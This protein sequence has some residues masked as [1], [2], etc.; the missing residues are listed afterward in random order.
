MV[1]AVRRFFSDPVRYDVTF[2]I[3]L[4]II[5]VTVDPVLFKSKTML[6]AW[7]VAA[8]LHMAIGGV[9]LLAVLRGLPLAASGVVAGI[10]LA[11]AIFAF[12]FS[13]AAIA[14]SAILFPAFVSAFGDCDG[15]LCDFAAVLAIPFI[16]AGLPALLTWRV[17]VRHARAAFFAYRRV[18]NHHRRRAMVAIGLVAAIAI[19]MLAQ[20]L[21][22]RLS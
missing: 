7:R 15:L 19:P 21:A 5:Y 1:A 18:A 6:G 8:Y 10:F 11:N 16:A 4:P 22:N 2:G 3:L 13:M 17:Y 12:L 9:V 14:L 20:S